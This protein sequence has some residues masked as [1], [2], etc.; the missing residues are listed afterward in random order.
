[1]AESF[2]YKVIAGVLGVLLLKWQYNKRIA[3]PR[4]AKQ[5][6][7]KNENVHTGVTPSAAHAA[8]TISEKKD[9]HADVTPAAVHAAPKAAHH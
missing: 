4:A 1:M 9:A 2:S 8:P 7:N 5:G 3:G 6:A